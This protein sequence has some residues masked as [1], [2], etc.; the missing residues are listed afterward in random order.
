MR[1]GRAIVPILMVAYGIATFL[2]LSV[3]FPL[4]GSTPIWFP[5]LEVGLG[6]VIL[7]VA[8]GVARGRRWAL[9]TAVALSLIA[10]VWS[11]TWLDETLSWYVKVIA[12]GV[13]LTVLAYAVTE[14]REAGGLPPTCRP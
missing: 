3:W 1:V 8:V 10:L 13:P 7:W 11:A 6:I 2:G 14:A 12:V 5:A 4:T 9:V